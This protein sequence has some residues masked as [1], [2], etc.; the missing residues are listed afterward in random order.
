VTANGCANCCRRF[1]AQ[2]ICI[3]LFPWADA[4]GYLLP[5]LRGSGN[6]QL[7]NL[8]F[9]RVIGRV[10]CSSLWMS[11]LTQ[12]REHGTQPVLPNLSFKTHLREAQ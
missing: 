1:A 11:M 12:S 3:G 4:H 9:G 5:P 8:R 2:V 7:Q 10:A 6:A